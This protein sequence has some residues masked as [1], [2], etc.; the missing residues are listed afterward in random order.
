M[1]ALEPVSPPIPLEI[2]F[3]PGSW[4][5]ETIDDAVLSVQELIDWL[6]QS[7]GCPDFA[8]SPSQFLAQFGAEFT[9]DVVGGLPGS[10]GGL[11]ILMEEDFLAETAAEGDVA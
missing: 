8:V 3:E 11:Y 5:T 9:S 1:G 7:H 4:L 6:T 2:I 10:F